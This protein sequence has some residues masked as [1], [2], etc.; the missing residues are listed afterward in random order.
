M[1]RVLLILMAT[2]LL[3]AAL[4]TPASAAFGLKDLDVAFSEEDGGAAVKAGTHPFAFTTAFGLNTEEDPNIGE[5]PDG[6]PK[7]VKDHENSPL[8]ITEFPHPLRL[9][10]VAL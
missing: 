1:K 9:P 6:S 8:T 2:A 7:N 5:V 3:A 10:P 4:A